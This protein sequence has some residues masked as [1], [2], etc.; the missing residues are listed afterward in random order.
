[1]PYDDTD[2]KKMIK[3]QTERK[4]G[5]SR[6]KKVSQD[7]KDLIHGIL[8]A[9][10]ERRYTVRDIN[11]SIWMLMEPPPAALPPQQPPTHAPSPQQQQQAFDETTADSA[12]RPRSP[13]APISTAATNNADIA[14]ANDIIGTLMR[15]ETPLRTAN[16]SS[17]GHREDIQSTG[18]TVV[19]AP[20]GAMTPL[21]FD[22]ISPSKRSVVMDRVPTQSRDRVRGHG[23]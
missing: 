19:V 22:D 15:P 20:V 11:E 1:M 3:Y 9:N 16:L 21:R 4:V 12:S 17:L 14:A 7:A 10:I 18:V 8:E 6:H 23:R 2:V 13:P 5:F